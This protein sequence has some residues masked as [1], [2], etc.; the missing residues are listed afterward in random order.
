MHIIVNGLLAKSQ[1]IHLDGALGAICEDPGV[2]LN[3]CSP[4]ILVLLQ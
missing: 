4:N 1:R 2:L 3:E